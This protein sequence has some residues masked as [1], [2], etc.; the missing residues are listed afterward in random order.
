[1]LTLSVSLTLR[2]ERVVFFVMA[3]RFTRQMTHPLVS[4]PMAAAGIA[5]ASSFPEFVYPTLFQVVAF[6]TLPVIFGF[7]VYVLLQRFAE[8]VFRP[9]ITMRE[10]ALQVAYVAIGVKALS[11][12]C[13]LFA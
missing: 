7:V 8:F 10:L 2:L 3:E 13:R 1:M 9:T 11:T 6:L 12:W 4:F 5:E